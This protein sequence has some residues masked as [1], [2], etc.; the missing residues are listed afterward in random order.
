MGFSWENYSRIEYQILSNY[1]NNS[2]SPLDTA[3]ILSQ[4]ERWKNGVS[5][6]YK[7]G[8]VNVYVACRTLDPD[9]AYETTRQYV[10]S[11]DNTTE[12]LCLRP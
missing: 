8:K 9:L 3:G 2:P 12:K 11:F 10:F 6:L 7:P 1:Q 4:W 5:S